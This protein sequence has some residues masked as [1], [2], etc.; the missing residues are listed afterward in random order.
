MKYFS[1]KLRLLIF[2]GDGLATRANDQVYVFKATNFSTAF[3]RALDLG[4]TAEHTYRN[5]INQDVKWHFA[6]VIF[7]D[8]LPSQD[9][10]GVEV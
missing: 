8:I 7:L 6:E 9:L 4:M 10:D 5:H 3:K 1:C 2:I